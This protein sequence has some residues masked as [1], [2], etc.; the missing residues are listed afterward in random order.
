[1]FDKR[2]NYRMHMLAIL[3]IAFC[4]SMFNSSAVVY[5]ATGNFFLDFQ[6]N[7]G[8][9]IEE[10]EW[11]NFSCNRGGGGGSFEDCD[12]NDEL[13]DD[14]GRDPTAFLME[15]LRG[16]VRGEA[17]YHVIIGLPGDD[18]V[19]ESYIKINPSFGGRDGDDDDIGPVSDSLGE[20]RDITDGRN[21][22]YDPRGPAVFSGSGTANPKSTLFRQILT[23]ASGGMRQ[24]FIKAEFNQK[25]LLNFTLDA[26]LV[27][28]DFRLDMT[29][30]TFD[31]PNTAGNMVNTLLITDPQF[32]GIPDLESDFP[33]TAVPASNQFDSTIDGDLVDVTGGKYRY[34]S[35]GI[36]EGHGA[37]FD[38]FAADW[39]DFF[40]PAQN[41]GYLYGGSDDD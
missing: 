12:E 26:E 4:T 37:G 29:N 30:S 23:D 20:S 36:Y 38:I 2:C 22:A 3:A 9:R 16:D 32:I 28:I 13:R 33:S 34:V 27:D 1:M 39:D 21:N 19:Q 15:Q 6:P 25:H 5:A 14:N 7:P 35:H 41:V 8:D 40:D 31:D 24:D 17:Y 18:F 11:L 10:P